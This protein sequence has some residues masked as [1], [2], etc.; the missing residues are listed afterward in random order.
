MTRFRKDRV[1][2]LMRQ[3]IS[4]LVASRVKD[5]RVAGVTITEVRM[6]PDLKS[7]WV[8][9]GT[10]ADGKAEAHMKGLVAAEGFIRR[11]LR[12]ELDLKYIPQLF[13]EYDSSFDNFDRINRLLKGLHDSEERDDRPDSGSPE[14]Q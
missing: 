8:Y 1:A 14:E 4:D 12:R 9:F 13:F 7:A 2:E 11:E 10:L 3:V 6:S 5:P